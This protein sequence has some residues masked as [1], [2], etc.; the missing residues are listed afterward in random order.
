MA[1]QRREGMSPA[2]TISTSGVQ[3]GDG[4]TG[5]VAT[6]IGEDRRRRLVNQRLFPHHFVQCYCER[7]CVTCAYTGLVSKGHANI[8]A[9]SW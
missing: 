7:G 3:A 5:I 6:E 1:E 2:A 8:Q 9:T 4:P